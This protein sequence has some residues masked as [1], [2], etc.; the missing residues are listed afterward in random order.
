MWTI[1]PQA[2]LLRLALSLAKE[3]QSVRFVRFFAE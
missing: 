3:A 1:N 2:A